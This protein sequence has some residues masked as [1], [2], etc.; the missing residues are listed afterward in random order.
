MKKSIP[1]NILYIIMVLLFLTSC[2][3]LFSGTTDSITINSEPAGATILIDGIDYGKT[4]T[5]F[6]LKRPGLSDKIVTLK[7]DGYEDRTFTLQK[8][9]NT[10]AIINLGNGLGW[11][12]DILTGAVNKYNPVNYKFELKQSKSAYK[13]NELD[14]DIYGRIN[15]PN[16]NYVQIY[17]TEENMMLIFLNE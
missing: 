12:V 6:V 11:L 8:E 15:L 17:D 9:F 14:K 16:S 1:I 10:V 4:P 3:T 2:A 7:L 5:T 13:L